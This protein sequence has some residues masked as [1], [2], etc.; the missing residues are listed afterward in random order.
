[1]SNETNS[2]IDELSLTLISSAKP[3][4]TALSIAMDQAEA[5]LKGKKPASKYRLAL[6]SRLPRQA[7][8]DQ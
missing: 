3:A 8:N 6:V 1:M 7:T 2:T 5:R 4:P